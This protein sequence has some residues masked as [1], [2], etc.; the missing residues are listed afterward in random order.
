MRGAGSE[1]SPNQDR[2]LAADPPYCSLDTSVALTRER[3]YACGQVK[4][5]HALMAMNRVKASGGVPL[6]G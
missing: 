4:T 2:G 5:F 3:V 6:D 1:G